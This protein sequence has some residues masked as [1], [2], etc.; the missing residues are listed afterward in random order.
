M[1]EGERRLAA[2]MY[3]DM[4]GYTTLGQRNESLSLALVEEQRKLIRPI[5]A[6]HNGREVKTMGDAFLVKFPNA[7]D[8]VRC[9]YDIQR[10]VREYNVPIPSDRRIHLRIGV[11]LGDVVEFQ[12]DISGDAVNI[13]SR[14]YPLADDGGVCITRPVYESMHNKFEMPFAS[15]GMKSLKNV[16]ERMEVYKMAIPWE[17]SAPSE[18][19]SYPTNRVA[20]LPFRSMS[21]DPND[22]YFAEG[23]TEEII[24]TVSGISGLEVISRTSIM[25]YKGTTKKVEDIGRELK[26]G[27]V[28]EGSFRKAGNRIRVTTQLI[29]VAKDKHL[30]AQNYDRNLDDIFEVQSD[31]AKQVA[32]ALRVRILSPELELVEKRHT[33]STTAYALYLKGRHLW[34]RRGLEDLRKAKEYFELAVHEDPAFAQGY[35]GLADC[36]LLMRNNW[37]IDREAN[38]DKTKAMLT[39]AIELDPKLAEAHATNGL[40]LVTECLLKAAEDEYRKAIELKPGYAFAR[41]WYCQLLDCKGRWDEAKE[42]IEKAAELDPHSPVVIQNVGVHYHVKR[43]YP[44]ALEFYR[45]AVELDPDYFSAHNSMFWAYG[46]M[47]RFDEMRREGEICVKLGKDTYPHIQEWAD[48]YSALC[49]DDRGKVRK[50]LPELQ[51]YDKDP[52][53]D[54]YPI[55][56]GYFLLGEIDRGFELMELAYS[57]WRT[58]LLS[59]KVDSELD[60][61]RNDPRYLDLLKRLGLD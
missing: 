53:W 49:E 42:Q 9:A 16:S 58:F 40:V 32:D 29:D 5:L 44:K 15:I 48:Y 17:Q 20:I 24:S 43:E 57:K 21:P 55:A 47:K 50:V 18:A 45:R 35:A 26:V 54:P 36:Y 6:R 13:A 59:M 7:L 22:E 61:V 33:D 39:K 2:I 11:H 56:W 27:S 41:M 19:S 52:G 28:L 8:A 3:T 10:T 4:V 12:G 25:G 34:N 31:V 38:L 51:T 37:G 23:M 1:S 46:R 60:V 30:W 14:I